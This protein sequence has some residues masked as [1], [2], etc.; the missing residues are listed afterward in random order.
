M[1]SDVMET[2]I[3]NPIE[4][5]AAE[6]GEGPTTN[7]RLPDFHIRD[8]F[9]P[10]TLALTGAVTIGI[11]LVLIQW[12]SPFLVP[13]LVALFIAALCLPIYSWFIKRGMSKT[14]ALVVMIVVVLLGF[15][16]IALLLL[17]G[18]SPIAST[19]ARKPRS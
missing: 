9:A 4:E 8:E 15:A 3:V 6:S 2:E 1:R 18:V 12:S 17:A 5:N 19:K 16:V 14:I 7:L 11:A 13:I 10:I